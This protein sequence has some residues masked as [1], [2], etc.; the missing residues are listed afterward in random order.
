M[1]CFLGPVMGI[2]A[3]ICGHRARGK[4]KREPAVYGGS[5][6][7]LAGLILG[8]LGLV[9]GLALG[10]LVLGFA[11]PKVTEVK[12]RN[13]EEVCAS[14]LRQ[15]VIAARSYAG[16]HDGR[17]PTEFKA[18]EENLGDVDVLRCPGDG[19]HRV[20]GGEARWE[21]LREDQVSYQLLQPGAREEEILGVPVLRCPVHGQVALGDGTVQKGRPAR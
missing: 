17:F 21:T 11:M 18:L 10:A 19:R 3:I 14:Q 8:Y 2:P 9:V 13:T 7:A 4:A 1:A 15:V 5:G 16:S 20:T 6:V 12:S